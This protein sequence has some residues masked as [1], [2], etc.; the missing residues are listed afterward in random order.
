M[1]NNFHLIGMLNIFKHYDSKHKFKL[2]FTYK[3]NLQIEI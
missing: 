1:N 3:H 2:F